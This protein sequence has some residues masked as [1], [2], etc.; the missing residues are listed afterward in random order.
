MKVL[1]VKQ[2]HN[3]IAQ[4][5]EAKALQKWAERGYGYPVKSMFYFMLE[6]KKGY[7]TKLRQKGWVAYNE[8]KACFGISREKAIANFN[9]R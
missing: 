2:Y 4:L 3:Q 1:Q 7:P 6:D 8:H 9:K 5:K